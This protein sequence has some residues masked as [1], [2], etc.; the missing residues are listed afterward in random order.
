MTRKIHD[1]QHK[2]SIRRTGT[3]PRRHVAESPRCTRCHY[4]L[5]RLAIKEPPVWGPPEAVGSRSASVHRAR[6]FPSTH[7]VWAPLIQ[8]QPFGV[9]RGCSVA[10]V[11]DRVM[12]RRCGPGAMPALPSPAENTTGSTTILTVHPG[13][14]GGTPECRSS[15]RRSAGDLDRPCSVGGTESSSRASGRVGAVL[16]ESRFRSPDDRAQEHRP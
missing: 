3:S 10:I 16:G 12:M 11:A 7:P 4:R 8:R 9:R 13:G 2:Y 14:I 15:A 6:R 1:G 5:G